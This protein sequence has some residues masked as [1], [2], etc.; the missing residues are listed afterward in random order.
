MK[1]I[2]RFKHSSVDFVPDKGQ[3]QFTN[4]DFFNA[5]LIFFETL[6]VFSL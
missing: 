4:E 6:D 3:G 5:T 1:I 2:D